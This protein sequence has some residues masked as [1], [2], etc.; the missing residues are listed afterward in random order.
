MHKSQIFCQRQ[1]N[2][3]KLHREKVPLQEMIENILPINSPA[4]TD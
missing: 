4:E 3:E 1:T 2:E